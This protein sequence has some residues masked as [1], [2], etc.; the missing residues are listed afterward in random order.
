MSILVNSETRILVQGISGRQGMYHTRMMREYGSR[1]VA[2]V[3]P[4][5][6]GSEVSGVPVYDT[7][8]EAVEA[9]EAD[10]SLVMVPPAAVLDAVIEAG[11][12]GI[13][14]VV[15]I[16]EH[17]PVHD[18]IKMRLAARERGTRLVGPNTIGV[19]S[20]GQAKIGIMPGFLYSPGPV[21]IISRSGTLTH[22]VASN[23]TYRGVGQSTCVGIGGDPVRGSDFVD[24]LPLMAADPETE[25]I[26]LIG[27]IGGE[28]EENAAA[29]LAGNDVGKPVLA[30]IA[31][32]TAPAGKRMGHAGALVSGTYGT[33]AAK[34]AA[35]EE[36][37]VKVARCLDELTD[38][39]ASALGDYQ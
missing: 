36:A 30:F 20:P 35:L 3:S 25:L 7:V 19:I 32:A 2:G 38:L 16:A 12:A 10:A 29:Y 17:V 9:C 8:A 1:V 11:D 23:L 4:G 22:E 37:G 14:L 15:V 21:G 6:G 28:G 13:G 34:V 18:A 31:G 39:A 26:I 33:Q 27:E 5:R 24:I